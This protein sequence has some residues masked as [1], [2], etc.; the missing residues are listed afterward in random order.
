VNKDKLLAQLKASVR[1]CELKAARDF[2]RLF[3]RLS[4]ALL[5]GRARFAPVALVTKFCRIE[6]P[7]QALPVIIIS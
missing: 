5:P 2:E 7:I 1:V 3:L 6:W 4:F